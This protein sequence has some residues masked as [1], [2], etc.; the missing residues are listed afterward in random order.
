[1]SLLR[2]SITKFNFNN[3]DCFLTHIFTCKFLKKE[4]RFIEQN[5]DDHSS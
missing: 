1:M 5:K 2:K 3:E 4:Y